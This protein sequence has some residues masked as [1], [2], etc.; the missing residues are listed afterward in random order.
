MT[1]T[2][3][4]C[5]LLGLGLTLSLGRRERVVH[6]AVITQLDKLLNSLVERNWLASILGGGVISVAHVHLPILLLLVAHH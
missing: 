6:A 5:S 1:R 4:L 3:V 2:R